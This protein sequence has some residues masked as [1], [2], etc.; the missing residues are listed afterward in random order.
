MVTCH[1]F[2]VNRLNLDLDDDYSVVRA[3]RAGG[4]EVWNVDLRG[5]GRSVGPRNWS[6]DD[7]VRLDVPAILDAAT[8][9]SR[10]GAVHWIGHSMGGLVILGHLGRRPD[11]PR[12]ASVVTIASPVKLATPLWTRLS[13]A[14]GAQ[15]GRVMDQPPGTRGIRYLAPL[16]RP[17]LAFPS[18]LFYP[19]NAAPGVLPRAV[20]RISDVASGRLIQQFHALAREGRMRSLDGVDDYVDNLAH[21]HTPLCVIAAKGD[22]IAPPQNVQLAYDKVTSPIRELHVLSREGGAASDYCHGSVLIGEAAPRDVY[23]LLLRWLD[24]R[25][26]QTGTGTGASV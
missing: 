13:L 4:Y 18:P 22:Q 20:W 24:A 10:V 2:G 23:P 9:R 25:T 5:V 3:L 17:R 15:V 19:P 21:I 1:G 7:H 16:L 11:D 26:D 14:L 6:F 8:T 12:V